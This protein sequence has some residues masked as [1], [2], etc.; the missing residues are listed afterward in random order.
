MAHAGTPEDVL[1]HFRASEAR[2]LRPSF[3]RYFQEDICD[4]LESHGLSL[5]VRENGRIFP[6]SGTAKDVV[7]I[8]EAEIAKREILV[9][10]EAPV[11]S[12]LTEDSRVT[13]VQVGEERIHAQQVIICVGG[14]SYPNSGTTGD[15]YSWLRQM[16]HTVVPVRAALAPIYLREPKAEWSGISLRDCVLKARAGS[17]I[18]GKEIA[19][20]REDLLFTHQGVSGPCALGISREIADAMA[21]GEEVYLECDLCPGTSY[22]A[23]AEEL[24][25]VTT[26]NPKGSLASIL[27]R[28]L[29]KK[30]ILQFE[31][32]LELNA[33][34]TLA[35]L[36]KKTRNRVINQI[37]NW[38]IGR[39]RTVPLEKGEVVSG[40][41]AL[42]EVDPKTM[43]SRLVSGLY[44][45]GEILDVAGPVGGYNLQA[46]WS[47]GFVA[48]QS[49]AIAAK[50]RSN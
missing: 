8:L 26:R 44:L 23:L 14:S 43:E 18:S 30:L 9:R 15:G 46:A 22:D 36:S 13:G 20:W 49:A 42:D 50:L 24:A 3:Y 35:S 4:L 12:I 7:R 29:A 19:R 10:R 2:F 27:E 16:G 48:G 6:V 45:C 47:T 31:L 40:G 21:S 37:K 25:E 41:V 32:D 17:A 34:T 11:V 28:W 1:K 38:V 33:G 39:V 5:Y